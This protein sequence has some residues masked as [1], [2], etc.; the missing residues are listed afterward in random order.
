MAEIGN[1]QKVIDAAKNLIQN[2][3][4]KIQTSVTEVWGPNAGQY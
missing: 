4:Q 1:Y 3:L 2:N